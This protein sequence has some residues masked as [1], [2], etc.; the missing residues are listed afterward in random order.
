MLSRST[1]CSLSSKLFVLDTSWSRN[2]GLLKMVLTDTNLNLLSHLLVA[3][4]GQMPWVLFKLTTWHGA[5]GP[6][7]YLLLS[8]RGLSLSACYL[9]VTLA[10]ISPP[11]CITIIFYLKIYVTSIIFLSM[12]IHFLGLWLFD[13]LF[14]P[15][16]W[17]LWRVLVPSFHFLQLYRVVVKIHNVTWDAILII[18]TFRLGAILMDWVLI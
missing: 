13:W 16:S 7:C 8:D 9:Y 2:I 15:W 6:F 4:I 5:F 17:D 10:N 3:V 12:M 14:L 1:N 11:I 18:Q